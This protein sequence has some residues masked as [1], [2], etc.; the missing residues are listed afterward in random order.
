M[1]EE[2][3]VVE[4]PKLKR[5]GVARSQL[6]WKPPS[7]ESLLVMGLIREKVS[8]NLEGGFFPHGSKLDGIVLFKIARASACVFYFAIINLMKTNNGFALPASA[9]IITLILIVG[10]AGFYFLRSGETGELLKEIPVEISIG[11]EVSIELGIQVGDITRTNLS[12]NHYRGKILIDDIENDVFALMNN[13]WNIIS[14]GNEP[15]SC[16]RG[17]SLGFPE[18]LIEDCVNTRSSSQTAKQVVD[19]LKNG[20]G[21][22][23]VTIVGTVSIP[24]DPSQGY[25]VSSGGED[26]VVSL[27]QG[28]FELDIL[29]ISDGEEVII[30][31]SASTVL[32]EDG[33]GV[34]II[35]ADSVNNT[36]NNN[37]NDDDE[38]EDSNSEGGEIDEPNV[39]PPPSFLYNILDIDNSGVEIQIEPE[40]VNQ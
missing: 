2:S 13:K 16:Q 19:G 18:S 10:V 4:V 24:S 39:S 29:N 5:L 11:R 9:I 8:F 35:E 33:E 6:V 32:N 27:K 15:F 14:V 23:S 31:G 38:N 1:S 26:V 37:N 7:L 22:S 17:R 40:G 12:G 25:K 30:D 21:L 34:V 20:E 36:S 3:T 28:E